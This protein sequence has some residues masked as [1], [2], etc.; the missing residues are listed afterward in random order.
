MKVL[1]RV[2]L[3]V[4]NVNVGGVYFQFQNI[5]LLYDIV[6]YI[7]EKELTREVLYVDDD[8]DAKLFL[9][10]AEELNL[11]E[12]VKDIL[13]FIVEKKYGFVLTWVKQYVL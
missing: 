7:F 4:P 2:W 13:N 3:E 6:N 11:P 10:A 5:E 12:K 1:Y 8:D 9:K